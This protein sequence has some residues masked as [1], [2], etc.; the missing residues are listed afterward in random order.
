MLE[1]HI[2]QNTEVGLVGLA[3]AHVIHLQRWLDWLLSTQMF[4]QRPEKVAVDSVNRQ[5]DLESC[6][7]E[8]AKIHG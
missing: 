4:F 7:E 2:N 1:Y 5:G 8:D 3:W 6:Q